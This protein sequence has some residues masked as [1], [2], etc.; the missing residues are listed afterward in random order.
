[1]RLNGLD[2]KFQKH[3][4]DPVGTTEICRREFRF[5]IAIFLPQIHLGNR[6]IAIYCKTSS[7]K[8][9]TPNSTKTTFHKLYRC[10]S[11]ICKQNISYN[12]ARKN[13]IIICS[14]I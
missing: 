5:Y 2:D 9:N 14:K 11:S 7:L 4:V 10:V 12:K 3:L 8:D 6:I 13:Y 1:M